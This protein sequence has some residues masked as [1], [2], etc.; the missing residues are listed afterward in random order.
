MLK[1][2]DNTDLLVD[3]LNIWFVLNEPELFY[4]SHKRN[5]SM[6]HG[7]ILWADKTE[8]TVED[9]NLPFVQIVGHSHVDKIS[10]VYDDKKITD[11]ILLKEANVTFT[12]C[13]NN[14]TKFHEIEL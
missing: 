10:Y 12:D 13:L 14:E 5:G 2:N 11:Q 8:W 1:L 7:S 3:E 4:I 9:Y 6:P